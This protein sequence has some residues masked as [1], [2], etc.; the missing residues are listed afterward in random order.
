[1][2][3]VAVMQACDSLAAGGLE[4]VAVNIAN[5]LPRD[6]F[7]SHLCTTR[8]DGPLAAELR[9]DVGRLSLGRRQRYDL[10]AVARFRRYVQAHNI[11]LVHAH[12]TALFF[13]ALAR[14]PHLLWHD[15]FGR[16]AVEERP[17]WLY[18]CALHR[19]AGVVAVNQPLANWARQALRVPSERVWYVPNFVSEP[20][21]NQSCPVLPGQ[22]GQRV[23]CVANFR[24][25]KDHATLLAAITLV[26]DAHLLLIGNGV[27]PLPLPA[28]V[29]NLGPRSDVSAILQ[30]CDVGVLSSASEGLPLALIEY[31]MNGLPAVATRVGQCAEVLDDGRAGLLVP[32]RAPGELAAAIGSLLESS[33]RRAELGR[34]FKARVLAQYSIGVGMERLARVYER[35]LANV[36]AGSVSTLAAV[37]S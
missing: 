30:R 24:P 36:P 2:N 5:H 4:R 8:R 29:T 17:A 19:A 27:P 37:P 3:P 12:G 10:A 28:N 23:V 26:P 11:R 15:H 22:P 32:A 6:R 7:A 21:V 31:G 33:A 25:E 9:S 35:V 13:A 20:S 18:R 1:M 14:P 34:A 16:C